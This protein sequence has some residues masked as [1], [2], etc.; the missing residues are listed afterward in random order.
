MKQTVSLGNLGDLLAFSGLME[1]KNTTGHSSNPWENCPL[2]TFKTTGG[3][4]PHGIQIEPLSESDRQYAIL[5]VAWFTVP[6]PYSNFSLHICW[7]CWFH[8]MRHQ[9]CPVTY[10]EDPWIKFCN[11]IRQSWNPLLKSYIYS[12]VILQLLRIWLHSTMFLAHYNHAQKG[13]LDK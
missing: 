10:S 3:Q 8:Y 5:S 2:C 4:I 1:L 9:Q 11:F 6:L 13:I 12:S 7:L